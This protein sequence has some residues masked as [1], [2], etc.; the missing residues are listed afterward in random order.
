MTALAIGHS[1]EGRP[2]RGRPRAA[3]PPPPAPQREDGAVGTWSLIGRD[4]EL[5]HL[6][7]LIISPE[8]PGVV[9]AGPAGVGKTRLAV[10]ALALAEQAGLAVGRTIAT[11]SAASLPFGALAHLLPAEAETDLSTDWS[12]LLRRSAAALIERA[13]GRR[14]CLL[15]DDAHLLDEASATLVYH[16][17]VTGT[18]FLLITVRSGEA[19]P[20]SVVAL[21]KDDLLERVEIEG[22]RGAAVEA[23]VSTMLNG[24][25]DPLAV[26]HLATRSQGNVLFLRELVRGAL[27]DGTLRDEG[28][29]WRLGGPLHPSDRVTELVDAR[30]GGLDQSQ[31]DVLEIVS[32]GEPLGWTE[33]TMLADPDVAEALERDGLLAS[34]FDGRRLNVRLAHPL[35]ADVLQARI[36][37]V[38]VRKI[39]RMLAEAVEATGARRREDILRVATWRLTGG[40]GDPDLMLSAAQTARWRYDFP[41]AERLARA[42]IDA[43]GAFE[44]RFTAAQLA[45][46]QGRS[47]EAEV[48]LEALRGE[49]ADDTQRGRVL[50]AQLDNYLYAS[51]P[52]DGLRVVAES[53]ALISSQEW[54][55]EVTARGTWVLLTS[56]SLRETVEAGSPL[57]SRV[58]GSARVWTTLPVSYALAK[59][60]QNEAAL[61]LIDDGYATHL[62][63]PA[64]LEWYPWFH[65]FV[66]YEALTYAGRFEEAVSLAREQYDCAL[67]DQSPEAQAIFALQFARTVADRG[68]ATSAVRYAQEARARFTELGRLNWI[69]D[70]LPVLAVAHAFAGQAR[71]AGAA[72]ADLDE[73]GP[74]NAYAATDAVTARAWAAVADNDVPTA[75]RL[76]REAAALGESTGERVAAAS[77]LHGLARVGDARGALPGLEGLAGVV[78]G[79]LMQRRLE[80]VRGLVRGDAAALEEASEAFERLGADLLA[81]EAAADAAVTWRKGGYPKKAAVIERTA[82]GRARRCEQPRTPALQNIE[83]RVH[84]TP[85]E[86]ETALLAAAGRSNKQIAEQ[87]VLSVRSIENRLQHVYEKLGVSRREDLAGILLDE[88]D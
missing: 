22:L 20:D 39:L 25:V 87:L 26:A 41:L 52:E 75:K 30:L 58:T 36:G 77:A 31:V 49:A 34:R 79:E 1:P 51:R 27:Q 86:R 35:Y 16:L 23:L 10:E 46:R 63:L 53:T 74:P 66:R 70:V 76:F 15:V 44:A 80:H 71:E 33:L 69:R 83:G 54:R 3:G 38:R 48:A 12:G 55:D 11:K 61:R 73:L 62:A 67:R 60:G 72:L 56:R 45:S 18:A 81:A 24:I 5:R 40:G 19:A 50:I 78:E 17:A 82:L 68:W 65:L 84:L 85:A 13:R 14:F 37:A 28:G 8:C 47:D 32:L 21:W 64:Q 9:L 43:G 29:L 7:S 57:L 88:D 2:W 6:G 42:A 4:A 59:M